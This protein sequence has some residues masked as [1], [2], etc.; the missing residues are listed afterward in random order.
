MIIC[1]ATGAVTVRINSKNYSLAVGEQYIDFLVWLTNPS[2]SFIIPEDAFSIDADAP[3]EHVEKLTRYSTFLNDFAEKRAS[4]I[5]SS[6]VTDAERE[7]GIDSLLE[8]L[9]SQDQTSHLYKN[10]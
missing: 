5:K 1:D 9:K 6:I 10:Q 7:A 4:I 8:E 2:N 3:S